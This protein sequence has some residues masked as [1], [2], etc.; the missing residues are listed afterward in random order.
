[1]AMGGTTA[2]ACWQPQPQE[3]KTL[4]VVVVF[5]AKWN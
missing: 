1:V 5:S 4:A 2:P 3:E